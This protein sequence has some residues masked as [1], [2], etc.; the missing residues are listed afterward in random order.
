[1]EALLR[2]QNPELGNVSPAEFIPIAEE[3][4]L[5]LPIGDW[6]LREACRQIKAWHATKFSFS[7]MQV[8]I[9]I[10]G[11]QLRQKDFPDRVQKVLSET[12]LEPRYLDLELTESLLMVDAEETGDILHVLHDMGVSFSV[13]DFGTGYSSLALPQALP[14]RHPQD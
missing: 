4:G 3:T 10:S 8:A 11:K 6:V 1:M 12:D 9:N 13:D 5:I 2:W 14:D 7:K